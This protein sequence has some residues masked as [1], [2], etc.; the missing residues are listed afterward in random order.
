MNNIL[1][2]APNFEVLSARTTDHKHALLKVVNE[3]LV[4]TRK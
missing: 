3:R 1:R 4:W 2:H